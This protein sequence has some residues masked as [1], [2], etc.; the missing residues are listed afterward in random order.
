M[1]EEQQMAD[2]LDVTLEDY[3]T[4]ERDEADKKEARDKGMDVW[5]LRMRRDGASEDAIQKIKDAAQ[6]EIDA[7]VNDS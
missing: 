5:E 7:I 6:A 1:T 2:L 3:R 4:W